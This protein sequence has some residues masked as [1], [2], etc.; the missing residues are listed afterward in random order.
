MDTELFAII[1]G[2]GKLGE[3]GLDAQLGLVELQAR[4]PQAGRCKVAV[5]TTIADRPPHGSVRVRGSAGQPDVT[6]VI[7]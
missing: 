2:T 6:R 7:F 4:I 1:G 3:P 5:G